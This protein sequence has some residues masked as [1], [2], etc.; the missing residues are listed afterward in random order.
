MLCRLRS[1]SVIAVLSVTAS[2][3]WAH[4]RPK[5]M[6]RAAESTGP[7]PAK[8][9]ITFSETVEPKLSSLILAGEKGA[10]IKTEHSQGDQVTQR[11]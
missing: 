5:V 1:L 6:I 7:T 9:V 11:R 8:I 4:A 10:P 3:S 2:L